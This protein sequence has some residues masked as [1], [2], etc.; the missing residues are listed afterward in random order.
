ELAQTQTHHSYE[1]RNIIRETTFDNYKKDPFAGT[2]KGVDHK[3]YDLWPAHKQPGH[4]WV[5]AIDMNACNG[6]GA[7]IVA[8]NAENNVPVVGREEV[9]RRREMHWIRIDRYYTFN[10]NGESVTEEGEINKLEDLEDVTVVNQPM[11]CQHC[12][13]APCETVC[14]VLATV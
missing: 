1:G 11:L 12:D 8:C 14:P 10:D 9:I 6:C 13:H 7:C 5:M 4:S 2:G 3:A